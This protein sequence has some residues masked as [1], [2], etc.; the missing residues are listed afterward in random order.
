M[1]LI[2]QTD[3]EGLFRWIQNAQMNGG[4]FITAIATAALLADTYNYPLL[5]PSLIAIRG[6]YPDY[7][8]PAHDHCP[9]CGHIHEGVRECG[10]DMG[11][12]GI[13]RCEM[14]VAA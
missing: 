13:C 3:N 6:R 2:A 1:V 14:E 5:R 8:A 7:E 9:R 12:G 4:G 10:A 11:G